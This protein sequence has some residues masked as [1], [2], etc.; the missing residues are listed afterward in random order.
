MNRLKSELLASACF[1]VT[2]A[3]CG[4]ATP[5]TQTAGATST[6]HT[7][8]GSGEAGAS[9]GAGDSAGD[10][11]PDAASTQTAAATSAPRLPELTAADTH[12]RVIGQVEGACSVDGVD[13]GSVYVGVGGRSSM[14]VRFPLA[15]G[16]STIVHRSEGSLEYRVASGIAAYMQNSEGFGISN[17]GVVPLDGGA[18][19]EVAHGVRKSTW[20]LAAGGIY[21]ADPSYSEPRVL[22]IGLNGGE[23]TQI[24]ELRPVFDEDRLEQMLAS[25]GELVFVAV[26][27]RDSSRGGYF[28]HE[29]RGGPAGASQTL[30]RYRRCP[31]DDEILDAV[32][33]SSG[34]VYYHRA[35]GLYRVPRSG[36][37]REETVIADVRGLPTATVSDDRF[38]VWPQREGL[39][40]LALG[41][42]AVPEVIGERALTLSPPVLSDG[43]I[44]WARRDAGDSACVILSRPIDAPALS[45]WEPT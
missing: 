2:L 15:G 35:E 44:Y 29:L 18:P 45:P 42:R 26:R 17:F 8:T 13:G 21:F 39:L 34:F 10:R 22:R 7:E 28:C 14:L 36:S 19:R 12:T 20:V 30:R 31:S 38:L 1:A 11:A 43:V 3:A 41:G 23:P 6:T 33:V 25:N 16:A 4:G 32:G 9:D 24:E 37:G 40:R 5:A 27:T